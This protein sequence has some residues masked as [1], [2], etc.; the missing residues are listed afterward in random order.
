MKERPEIPPGSI[1][2][3]RLPASDT[4]MREEYTYVYLG[5]GVWCDRTGEVFENAGFRD[6][7]VDGWWDQT[8]YIV[9]IL[10]PGGGR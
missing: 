3:I 10:A 4:F 6:R 2:L 5:C 9:Q 1:V 8:A 7:V